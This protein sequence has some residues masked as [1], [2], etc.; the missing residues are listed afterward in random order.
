MA[1]LKRDQ[2]QI[3]GIYNAISSVLQNLSGDR[4]LAEIVTPSVTGNLDVVYLHIDKGGTPGGNLVVEVRST[5]G[6]AP[7]ATVLATQSVTEAS[8]S[9]KGLTTVTFSSPASLTS[10]TKYA[11]CVHNADGLGGSPSGTNYY[12]PAIS[13]SSTDFYGTGNTLYSSSDGG[14]NWSAQSGQDV[15][16]VTE[17]S[18]APTGPGVD[19]FA[20]CT[21]ADEFITANTTYMAQTFIPSVNGTLKK[22]YLH[23]RRFDFQT[24]GNV[25]FEVKAVDGSNKPTG[26]A[27]ASQS[28]AD[29]SL[30]NADNVSNLLVTFTTPA[31]LVSGTTYAVVISFPNASGAARYDLI[32][33]SGADANIYANGRAWKSTDSGSTWGDHSSGANADIGFVT[34]MEEIETATQT[35]TSNAT[36]QTTSTQTILS[37]AF[38]GTIT[39]QTIL[40][41]AGIGATVSQTIL[42]D[43][44]VGATTTQT[45]LSNTTIQ[46]TST[47]TILSDAKV[48]ATST[49]TINSNTNVQVT[50]SQF[51]SSN[52][53]LSIQITETILSGAIIIVNEPVIKLYIVV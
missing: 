45:I 1:T 43:A 42:S 12:A 7:T 25:V 50:T 40:S 36:I 33:H 9:D 46:A 38:V 39:T 21:S 2:F 53:A 23:V 27:L 26:S 22:F 6:G 51:I 8:V 52:A 29:T 20:F 3:R 49:Q 10:G 19:Q 5:S 16:F 17:M 32:M 35:I 15:V 37:D 11:I 24:G 44:F 31:T 48:Q 47:Q 4:R 30:G 28:V 41:N 14:A 18:V 34:Y 13:G